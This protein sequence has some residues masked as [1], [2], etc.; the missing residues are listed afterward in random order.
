MSFTARRG[1]PP[2]FSRPSRTITVTLPEDTLETLSGVDPD[3]GLAIVR[4]ALGRDRPDRSA[5]VEVVTFGSRAVIAVSRTRALS[6]MKGV[7][8]VPLIDGRFL[9]ALD[10]GM[11]EPHFEL[12]VRDA[13]NG[14]AIADGDRVLLERLAQVLREAR[15]D[16]SLV[17]RRIMVLHAASGPAARQS[18]AT[19]S[20]V[21]GDAARRRTGARRM[22]VAPGSGRR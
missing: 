7:E 10:E 21:R 2:K 11:S 3:I 14:P 15:G 16:G 13:L 12:A 17:L 1:R 6:G 22:R 8:L 5:G 20:R 9:I 18:A 19:G 4:L